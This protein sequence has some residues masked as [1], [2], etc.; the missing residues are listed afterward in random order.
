[1]K[2]LVSAAA[3]LFL[4]GLCA[5]AEEIKNVWASF[6]PGSWVKYHT[7]M[8]SEMAGNKTEVVS[9]ATHTL[10]EVTDTEVTVEVETT[11][12]TKMGGQEFK[13]P[14]QKTEVKYP[15]TSEA[16]TAAPAD[17]PKPEQG[18]EEITVAGKKIACKWIKVKTDTAGTKMET[19][20]YFSESI[21]GSMVKTVS[22]GEGAMTMS[23]TIELVG[24]EVK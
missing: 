17:G 2:R 20:T 22:K 19:Q 3:F 11:T 12:T 18:E 8:V 23:T 14:A 10:K 7:V 5:N 21:P 1:M 15:R 9:D 13:S 4:A 6:K 24:Y 16:Q